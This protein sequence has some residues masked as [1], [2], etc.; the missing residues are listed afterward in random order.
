MAVVNGDV[1]MTSGDD[2]SATGDRATVDQHADTIL[3]TGGV[4]AIQGRNQL[5]GER[6]FVERATGKTQ[7]SS[8]GPPAKSPGRISTRFYRG[9]EKKAQTPKQKVQQ[10]AE[11]AAKAAATGAVGVFKTDPTAPIDVEAGRLDVDDRAKQ[12]VFKSDVHAVQGDFVVRTSELRA[13]TPAPPGSPKRTPPGDK[14]APAEIT[15]IEARGAVIVTSKNGQNATG[16]WADFN[17]KENQ[18]VAGRRRHLNA[19]EERGTRIEADD[20]HADRRE[21]HSQRPRRRLVGDVPRRPRR[22]GRTLPCAQA[23]R[24]APAQFF[25]LARKS[26]TKR[27]LQPLLAMVPAQQ[28]PMEAGALGARPRKVNSG[29]YAD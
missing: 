4:V 13:S 6:L 16:D 26:R 11:E 25:T 28:A 23:P 12:A 1:E 10:L 3:L 5:K 18:V 15:R 2:R 8:P 22:R 27:S 19:G 20:R 7:L 14:K 9:E 29:Q 21:R 17:V 24:A